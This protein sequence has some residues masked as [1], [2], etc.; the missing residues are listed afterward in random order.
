M[1]GVLVNFPPLIVYCAL[2]PC[3]LVCLALMSVQGLRRACE[4]MFVHE[5]GESYMHLAGKGWEE[6]KDYFFL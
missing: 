1:D 6:K 3:S 5:F 2:S 4:C